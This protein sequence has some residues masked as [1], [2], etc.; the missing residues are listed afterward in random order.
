MITVQNLTKKYKDLIVLEGVNLE[1]QDGEIY[2]LAGIS[3]VGKSTFL[4]CLNGLEHYTKGS[5]CVDGICVEHLKGRELREF[6]KN[7]GM[8]FQNFPLISR[9]TVHQN[10]AFPMEC[11]GCGKEETGRRVKELAALVGIEDKLSERPDNLS[12]GQKQRAAI[13]RADLWH[14]SA[15]RGTL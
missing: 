3:G 11:W 9:K 10:I 6:R 1:I 7:I 8:I 12:G 4:G 5:I 13:A 2:G 15:A 14:C